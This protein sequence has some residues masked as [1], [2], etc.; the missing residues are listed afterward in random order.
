ME[1]DA[2]LVECL[3]HL[4]V[5]FIQALRRFGGYRCSVVV[6]ILVVNFRVAQVRPLGVALFRRQLHPVSERFQTPFQEPLR[7]FFL[8]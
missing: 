6:H 2:Q 7:L 3:Q 8:G 1:G 4:R 5:D